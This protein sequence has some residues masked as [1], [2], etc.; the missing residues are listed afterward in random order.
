[1]APDGMCT[2]LQCYQCTLPADLSEAAAAASWQVLEVFRPALTALR[3]YTRRQLPAV[4]CCMGQDH[5]WFSMRNPN[6]DPLTRVQ[7]FEIMEVLWKVR[8]SN[9]V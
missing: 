3:S 8:M 4:Q 9:N 2:P 7:E 5:A 1:M 6:G